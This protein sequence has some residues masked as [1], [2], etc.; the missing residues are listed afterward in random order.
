MF[1]DGPPLRVEQDQGT[2]VLIGEIDAHNEALVRDALTDQPD[3]GDVRVDLSGV[4][5]IDSS[6]L[7]VVLGVHQQL[8]REG[9][10]LVLVA[11]SH[12][13]TRLIHVAG[14]VSHLHV[15]PQP[16]TADTSQRVA[17]ADC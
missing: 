4:T 8:I 6:G 16:D 7:R 2:V 3:D 12:V 10:R 15:E 9:R 1:S 11:P 14:V 5:F 17:G 13:V